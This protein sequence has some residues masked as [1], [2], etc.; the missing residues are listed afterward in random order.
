MYKIKY[1]FAHK[2]HKGKIL[3]KQKTQAIPHEVDCG[4]PVLVSDCGSGPELQAKA[5][6]GFFICWIT[7]PAAL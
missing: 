3:K 1:L 2:K 5:F 4:H 6:C 7:S